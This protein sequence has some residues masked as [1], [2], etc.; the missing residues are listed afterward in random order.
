MELRMAKTTFFYVAYSEHDNNTGFQTLW[1]RPYKVGADGALAAVGD[2]IQVAGNFGI[3]AVAN[4][5]NLFYVTS[6]LS[7]VGGTFSYSLT[8]CSIA[9]D[10]SLK[11]LATMD[12][13]AL[14]DPGDADHGAPTL[15][16]SV[17]FPDV[18]YVRSI[19]G[20]LQAYKIQGKSFAPIG[21]PMPSMPWAEGADMQWVGVDDNGAYLYTM[22]LAGNGQTLSAASWALR[23]G[24][25]DNTDGAIDRQ[26]DAKHIDI[27]QSF[28]L[29]Q[30]IEFWGATLTST[31]SSRP[32]KHSL[33]YVLIVGNADWEPYALARFEARDGV[34]TDAGVV[35]PPQIAWGTGYARNLTMAAMGD[36]VYMADAD[37]FGGSKVEGGSN[38]TA[39]H[40]HTPSSGQAGI[41]AI[42]DLRKCLCAFD[43]QGVVY[44][45]GSNGDLTQNPHKADIDDNLWAMLSVARAVLG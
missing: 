34:F 12:V 8:A 38:I 3:S 39:S 7:G 25:S 6:K 21:N 31:G 20:T 35:K 30:S 23:R 41:F 5:D 19:Q 1:L 18:V 33:I 14:G 36:Y 2:P 9:N 22:N 43:N 28:Q 15:L 44:A 27:P 24:S 37:F 42:D 4:N 45:I 26:T 11:Q 40:V 29:G 16:C 10:A 32:R 13:T 17:M